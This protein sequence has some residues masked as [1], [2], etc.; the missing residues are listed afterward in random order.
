VFSKCFF[1]TFVT[2][3]VALIFTDILIWFTFFVSLYINSH[4]LLSFP[5]PFAWHPLPADVTSIS[6]CVL[7]FQLLW[8]IFRNFSICVPLD[9]IILLQFCVYL[10]AWLSVCFIFMPFL[11]LVLCLRSIVN[12]YTLCRVSLSI[13]YYPKCGILGLGG[14]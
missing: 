8:S 1:K 9:S 14:E 2:I 12:V 10:P 13:H 6:M 7:S 3:L 11:Y 4:I 5:P